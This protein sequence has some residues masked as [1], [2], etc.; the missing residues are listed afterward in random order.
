MTPE[1]I[2]ELRAEY[3]GKWFRENIR[4]IPADRVLG[5]GQVAVDRERY[6]LLS[7]I[8]STRR[9]IDRC[10]KVEQD[11]R[12]HQRLV[13]LESRLDAL[14]SLPTK[15]PAPWPTTATPSPP[16]APRSRSPR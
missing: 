7:A 1:R 14:R 4:A 15:E 8:V 9:A 6:Q 10:E 2:A 3:A 16:H 12:L 5:E 13:R 11:V